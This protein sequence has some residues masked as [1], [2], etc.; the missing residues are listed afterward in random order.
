MKRV[1]NF[2]GKKLHK[3]GGKMSNKTYDIL[4][5]I[6][7]TV[8]PALLTLFGVIGATMNWDFTDKVITIGTAVI[9]CLGTIIGV[10][11]VNYNKTK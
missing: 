6:V 7:I 9:T 10:S 11:S 8:L 1:I 5:W 3:G 2:I 4:K